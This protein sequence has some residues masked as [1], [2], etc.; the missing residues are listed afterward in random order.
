[1]RGHLREACRHDARYSFSHSFVSLLSYLPLAHTRRLLLLK[2]G[3]R[4]IYNGALGYGPGKAVG[5]QAV[6]PAAG[7]GPGGGGGGQ[8]AR[9]ISYLEGVPG[10]P[11]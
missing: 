10:V 2:P 8:Q 7:G 9:L 5:G 11:R 4:I 1:M 3:G 6:V